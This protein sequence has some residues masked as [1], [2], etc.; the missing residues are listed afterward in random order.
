MQKY[1]DKFPTDDVT[2]EILQTIRQVKQE[3]TD[4]EKQRRTIRGELDNLVMLVTERAD[5]AEL[6]AALRVI[7]DELNAETMPRMA[8]YQASRNVQGI[9]PEE[10]LS[11]AVG[12][13]LLGADVATPNLPLTLSAWRMHRYVRDYLS[14][15]DESQAHADFA[16]Y[17]HG[18]RGPAGDRRGPGGPHASAV[19]F[20]RTGRC[21]RR[22]ASTRWRS[23]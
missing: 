13:W 23:T 14:R 17:H 12:G 4:F 19:S 6:I 3:Y 21:E 8:A 22:P 5:R 16:Q 7:N 2:G 11:L 18:V 1:L 20:A 9:K 15:A 10:L